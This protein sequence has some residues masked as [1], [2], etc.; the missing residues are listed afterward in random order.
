MDE[1]LYVFKEKCDDMDW[2]H[3]PQ[4]SNCQRA[5]FL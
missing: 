2:I 4:D 5:K 1:K 3:V